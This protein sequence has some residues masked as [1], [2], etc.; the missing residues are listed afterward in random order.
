MFP[1]R[2][3]HMRRKLLVA[4]AILPVICL[5]SPPASAS[6]QG[7]RTKISNL[8]IFGSGSDP[9]FLAGSAD[10]NN[11]ASV[12][13]HGAHFIPSAVADNGSLISFIT[14]AISLNV[15]NAPIG[16]TSGGESF[17]FEAGVPVRT[18]TSSG[19]IFGERGQTLGKGRTVV[20]VGQTRSHFS[21]LRGVP[22]DNVELFFTHQNV[23]FDG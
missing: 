12:Q 22:L 10:P 19:P 21:S 16:S 18:S 8:F 11:P 17:H 6:G 23:N 13:A 9:L 7:L 15:A 3:P 5:L 14:T 1:Q 2:N 4:A 20:G